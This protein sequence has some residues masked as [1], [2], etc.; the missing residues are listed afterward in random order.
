MSSP[1][2]VLSSVQQI[3]QPLRSASQEERLNHYL[4]HLLFFVSAATLFEGYDAVITGMALPYLGK[5]FGVG[6]KE[7]GFAASMI[8]RCEPRRMRWQTI[9]WGASAWSWLLP[10]SEFSPPRLGR[11]AWR[12]RHWL[13]ACGSVFHSSGSS[14]QRP[15]RKRWKRSL[16]AECRPVSPGERWALACSSI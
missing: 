2:P 1:T 13:L 10:W 16:T 7:L 15:G 3:P 11:L 9:S 5:D 14:Y 6:P 4:W 8:S 12:W